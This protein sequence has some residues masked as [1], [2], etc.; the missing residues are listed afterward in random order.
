MLALAS[1]AMAAPI[2]RG[3]DTRSPARPPMVSPDD[4]PRSARAA[5]GVCLG[6]R[7]T[8]NPFP[9]WGTVCSS[10]AEGGANRDYC[11]DDK[12]ADGRSAA[13]VCSECGACL[14]S[15]PGSCSLTQTR[16]M[17]ASLGPAAAKF[18]QCHGSIQNVA[19]KITEFRA[20]VKD[21]NTIAKD[22]DT[23]SG[24]ISF[25]LDKINLKP[26]HGLGIGHMVAKIP[27]VG[28]F[29]QMG[30]KI[31]GKAAD[32]LELVTELVAN[33]TGKFHN[34]TKYIEK[35]FVTTAKVT[36]PVSTF[37]TESDG[38]LT[39]AIKCAA[40]GCD[41]ATEQ[42]ESAHFEKRKKESKV[43][44]AKIMVGW[45]KKLQN[46]KDESIT[47]LRL[48]RLLCMWSGIRCNNKSIAKCHTAKRS[49]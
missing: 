21:I 20:D 33:A 1:A 6:D 24:A 39:E 19:D 42:L 25:I 10:Y 37:L 18:A 16:A 36:G 40:A 35:A 47:Q 29:I 26:P 12:D 31:A 45:Q 41:T 28:K 11:N 4:H 9:H 27:K 23:A 32:V 2:D 46:A 14:E 8:F 38:V 5:I 44:Y 7:A 22:L 30:L 43:G 13:E 48:L 15:A 34:A 49:L 3:L 17:S